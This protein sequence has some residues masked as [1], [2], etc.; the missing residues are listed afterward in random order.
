MHRPKIFYSQLG[1]SISR[2]EGDTLV[3][4]TI[5]MPDKNRQHLFPTLFVPGD[6]KWLSG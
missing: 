3:I 6:G 5:G 4:E 1:D 2:W